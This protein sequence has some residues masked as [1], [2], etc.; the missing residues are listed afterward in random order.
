M[1]WKVFLYGIQWDDGKGEYDVSD[2]PENL[3]VEISDNVDDGR[4]ADSKEEAIV[5]ALDEAT[6]EYDTLIEGTEQ[7]NVKRT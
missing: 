4:Y 7:I 1:T 6:D 5:L 2:L 3:C